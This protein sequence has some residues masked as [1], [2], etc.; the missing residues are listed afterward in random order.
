MA[1]IQHHFIHGVTAATDLQYTVAPTSNGS[2]RYD[3]LHVGQSDLDSSCG[4]HCVVM[5][6]MVLCGMPRRSIEEMSSARRGPLKDL[7]ELARAKYFDGTE[8][9]DLEAYVS[10]F[11]PALTCDTTTTKS[12]KRIGAAVAKAIA[13][14]HVAII[15]LEARSFSHWVFLAGLEVVQGEP[16]PR[17][18]LVLDPSAPRPW[19]SFYNARLELT[20]KTSAGRFRKPFVHQYRYTDGETHA[21]YLHGLVVVKRVAQPP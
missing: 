18:L 12:V 9:E 13:A 14:G 17:A 4:L 5:A 16:A 10:A 6:A 20:T 3:D 11:A 15:G 21:T 7:W 19:G 1:G 2:V 8:V